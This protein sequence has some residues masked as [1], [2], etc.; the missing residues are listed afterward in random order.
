MLVTRKSGGID[1]V[2][3][4][5]GNPGMA[6]EGTRHTAGCDALT[7]LARRNGIPLNK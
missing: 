7:E 3:V 4:G 2:V 5:L 1:F 6:Y